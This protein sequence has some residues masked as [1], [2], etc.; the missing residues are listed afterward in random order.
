MI[1][2]ESCSHLLNVMT[3]ADHVIIC[4]YSHLFIPLAENRRRLASLDLSPLLWVLVGRVVGVATV[5]TRV[6][7]LGNY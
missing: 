1:N 2:A 3:N 6:C 5:C 7:Y 4:L